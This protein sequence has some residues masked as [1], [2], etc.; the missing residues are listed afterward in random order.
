MVSG[1][2]AA[3]T[4]VDLCASRLL[5]EHLQ[6]K[7]R[8]LSPLQCAAAAAL[9]KRLCGV[10]WSTAEERSAA[11]LLVLQLEV[12]LGSAKASTMP[13]KLSRLPQDASSLQG[14][15]PTSA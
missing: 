5:V 12:L 2:P 4:A 11:H 6:S 15:S 9:Q 7:P 3:R 1:N 14:D 8:P 13:A 10:R